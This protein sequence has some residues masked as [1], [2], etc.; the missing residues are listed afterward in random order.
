MLSSSPEALVKYLWIDSL[1]II[2]D[3]VEDWHIESGKMADIYSDAYL[4]IGANMSVDCN[5]GFLDPQGRKLS[6]SQ[7]IAILENLDSTT[8]DVYAGYN[9]TGIAGKHDNFC[10]ISEHASVTLAKRA[11]CLQEQLLASRLVHFTD[12]E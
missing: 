1:C 3:D 10:N 11:W 2:Q 5:G 4:V 7:K 8:S 12:S 6:E 9:H